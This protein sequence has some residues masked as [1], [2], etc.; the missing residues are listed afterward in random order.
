MTVSA[1]IPQWNRR[2]L[3]ETLL[4]SIREQTHPF[5]EV[6]VVDN[7]STD[8]SVEFAER[9]GARVVRLKANLGF[10]VAV[11]RGIQSATGEWIAILNNDITLDPRWLARLVDG[12]SD[13]CFATGKILSAHDHSVIDGAFDEISLGAC[14][15]RCGSGKPDSAFWNKSRCIRFAPMTAALFRKRLFDE[16]GFLDERFGSYLEDVDFGIRCAAAARIGA[17]I[18]EAIAYHAGSATQGRWNSD[19]IRSISRNQILLTVKHF[20]GSPRWP[21][22]AGQLLW[23]MLA[24]R[25]G[26]GFAW[27][28]GRISG[29]RASRHVRFDEKSNVLRTIFEDSERTIFEVQQQT[30]FDWYWRA[31]FWLRSH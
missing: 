18:P 8:D 23:G 9:N 22:V 1:V 10:A 30:G 29:W 19:T 7:G 12:A 6:I 13:V 15:H 4:R 27:L 17:Y 21:I 26:G 5:D 24:L 20:R 3:L 14:A 11:N 2:G 28:R 25:H 16:I 31:Y